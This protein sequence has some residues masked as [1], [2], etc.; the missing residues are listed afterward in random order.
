M[1]SRYLLVGILV[2]ALVAFGSFQAIDI[3]GSASSA[4]ESQQ[5]KVIIDDGVKIS[6]Y[7]V[8]LVQQET[9]FDAL[10]RVATPDYKMLA[11]SVYITSINGIK[12]DSGHSWMF[13]VNENLPM[14]ACDDYYP[15]SGD[16]IKFRYMTTEEAAGYF[17]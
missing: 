2:L 6:T 5:V 4:G 1:N 13:F 7:D 11:P 10:T 8:A 9:A 16:V 17:E 14:V 15:V 3:T 12:E